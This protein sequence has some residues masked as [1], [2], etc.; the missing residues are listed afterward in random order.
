MTSRLPDALYAMEV[1]WLEE[2]CCREEI[3]QGE[4]A[5]WGWTQRQRCGR[6]LH[7]DEEGLQW[8]LPS[9]PLYK[10]PPSHSGST[11]DPSPPVSPPH[12]PIRWD[13][14]STMQC[15][16]DAERGKTT[17]QANQRKKVQKDNEAERVC[18][19]LPTLHPG[20]VVGYLRQGNPLFG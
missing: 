9:T 5:A 3:L 18:A 19:A 7:A 8:S 14:L 20:T 15:K 6:A 12:T 10:L 1:V 17:M 13:L 11:P 2:E 4:M 16:R